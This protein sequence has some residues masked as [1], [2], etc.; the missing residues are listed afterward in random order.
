MP[1]TKNCVW[2]VVNVIIN[3]IFFNFDVSQ[4]FS[5]RTDSIAKRQ[6]SCRFFFLLSEFLFILVR[7]IKC[8]TSTKCIVPTSEDICSTLELW[9]LY[10][11]KYWTESQAYNVN[12]SFMVIVTWVSENYKEL[13]CNLQFPSSQDRMHCCVLMCNGGGVYCSKII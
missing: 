9:C 8:F 10:Q 5:K 11:K 12:S 7:L 3:I 1:D 6:Q 13:N 4:K 2:Y